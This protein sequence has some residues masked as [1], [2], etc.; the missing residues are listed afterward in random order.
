MANTKNY[1]LTVPDLDGAANIEL[2][3]DN[4][5]IIDEVLK[6]NSCCRYRSGEKQ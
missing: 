6:E 1:N 2:I 5:E 3:G 4:M